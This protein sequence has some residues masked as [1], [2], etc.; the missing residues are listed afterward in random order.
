M[1]KF[2]INAAA[3]QTGKS[4]SVIHRYIQDGKLSA[5][6]TVSPTG[7]RTTYQIDAAELFRV[8]PKKTETKETEHNNNNTDMD[9]ELAEARAEIR[10]L[11]AIN[12]ELKDDKQYLKNELSKATETTKLITQSQEPSGFLGLGQLLRRR[13]WQN[14]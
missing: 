13:R 14:N 4:T 9:L 6:K 3:K 10:A 11:Q 5:E 8:F 12:D 7:R 2:S 1:A